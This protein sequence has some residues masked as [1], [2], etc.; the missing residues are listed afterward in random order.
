MR[1][2]IAAVAGVLLLTGCTGTAQLAAG[3]VQAAA[4][5]PESGSWT[6]LVYSIADT[7]LEPPMMEDLEELASVGTQDGL[8]VVALVDRAAGY[9]DQ[10]LLGL[11]NW[12]GGKLLEIGKNRATEIDDLGNV[13]TGDPAVLAAFIKDGIAAYP[14]EHYAL[15]ISDH[16]ASWPGVG[17]DM[18]FDND[19]LGLDEL[20]E[21]L[22]EG[23]EGLAIG[24]L[25]VIGFDA[26]LMAT[27]E[28]ASALAPYA[29]RLLASQELEP[30]HGWDYAAFDEVADDGVATADELN[31]AIIDGYRAQAVANGTDAEITLSSVD[32]TRIG[33]LE[34]AMTA[35]T[36]VLVERAE[37]AAAGVGQ[38]LAQTLGVRQQPK[39][40]ERHAHEGSRHPGVGG[41]DRVAVRVRCR[42]RRHPVAERHRA[43]PGG[44]P[45]RHRAPPDSP[46]TSRLPPSTTT[47]TTTT[48][49]LPGAGPTSSPRTTRRVK[50]SRWLTSLSSPIRPRSRSARTR[51][52]SSPASTRR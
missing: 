36:D 5:D 27:Y 44:R 34:D 4:S 20:D 35:F 12:S 48:S 2:R 22:N 16:G 39:S 50:T 18:S 38:S 10:P 52:P 28:V 14:A 40:R 49:A 23:L 43:R 51:R 29:D 33:E 41:G 46:S 6:I 24:K 15:I 9:T 17:A 13:N 21:A 1:T 19:G 37:T 7:N 26:C 25:D 8:N 30:G 3:N 47:R 45:G 42:R 11:P 31:S 32:L